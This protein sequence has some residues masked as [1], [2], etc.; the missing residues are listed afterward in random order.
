M[1]GGGDA[2][3]AVLDRFGE[4]Y[5]NCSICHER[6]KQPKILNCL[7]SFCEGC[8][9]KYQPSQGLVKLACPI[10]RQETVILEGGIPGLKTNFNL[11]GMVEAFKQPEM[12]K[13]SGESVPGTPLDRVPTPTPRT[14]LECQKHPG[15]KTWFYCEPCEALVC[16]V[17]TA[18][19]H[20]CHE[21]HEIDAAATTCRDSLRVFFPRIED[22]LVGI[23]EELEVAESVSRQVAAA[24]DKSRE[25]VEERASAAM[26]MV[27]DA[28]R[29]I[30]DEISTTET[31]ATKPMKDRN[32]RLTVLKDRMQH[33]VTISE[34]LTDNATDEDLLSLFPIIQADL[35]RLSDR[36]QTP[37]EINPPKALVMKLLPPT[38]PMEID[39]GR[40]LMKTEI[41]EMKTRVGKSG[42]DKED[43]DGARGITVCSNGG[44]AVADMGM[45]TKGIT[46][47]TSEWICST[48]VKFSDSKYIRN[49]DGM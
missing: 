1:A 45:W 27:I 13:A 25:E 24:A 17:C 21:F 28:R 3:S 26:A 31:E 19:T 43:F 20:K 15:E 12:I 38:R 5:L 29:R 23:E 48:A 44:V 30:L 35:K 39:L 22:L 41:W 40:L 6:Y 33:S 46:V 16:Q 36:Q 7:H 2:M 4:D 14:V 42:C 18:K 49:I 47:F 8:L 9:G 32:K 34:H 37:P 11:S 10:C